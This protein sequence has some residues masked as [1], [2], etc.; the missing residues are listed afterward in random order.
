MITV[1]PY[2]R[3]TSSAD[4]P[5]DQNSRLARAWVRIREQLVAERGGLEQSNPTSPRIKP[6]V[7]VVGFIVGGVR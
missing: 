7:G 2:G 5:Q 3:L 4:H 1:Y 6:T